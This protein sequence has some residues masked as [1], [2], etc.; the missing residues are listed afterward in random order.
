MMSK[1][2]FV[3]FYLKAMLKAATAGGV[4]DLLYDDSGKFELVRV[5]RDGEERQK[6]N[7]TGDSLLAIAAD[8]IEA[9]RLWL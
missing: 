7:V 5:F 8:V 6:V 3:E 4:T 1:K 2:R 9:V